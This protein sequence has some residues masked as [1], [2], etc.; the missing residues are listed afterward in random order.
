MLGEH[1]YLVFCKYFRFALELVYCLAQTLKSL[2]LTSLKR[3]LTF[4][5]LYEIAF[6]SRNEVLLAHYI[7][8]ATSRP[9]SLLSVTC[10]LLLP[11]C[12]RTLFQVYSTLGRSFGI[13]L[14]LECCLE[15]DLRGMITRSSKVVL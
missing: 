12:Q 15:N 2:L 1:K 14:P 6:V 5:L 3:L 10:F 8:T 4:L 11:L 13:E 7:T 9:L